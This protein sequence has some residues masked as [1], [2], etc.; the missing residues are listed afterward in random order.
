MSARRRQED[1]FSALE[2][3]IIVM[4]I[5]VLAAISV[6]NM[7]AASRSYKVTIAAEA[8]SQQLNRCRQEA[9]RKNQLV[10]IQ[11][12][13]HTTAIDLDDGGTDY[14]D[15]GTLVTVASDAT[16]TLV[17]PTNGIVTFTSRGEMPIGSN[18]N[19]TVS[20]GGRSRSVTIDP[21]GAVTIGAE[22]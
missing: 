16:I 13:A 7:V 4:V 12:T 5:L 1:G 6:P 20:Y 17:S 15:D 18:P 19:F 3:V 21:R 8:L 9:V 2:I 22:Q 10:P 14:T 11:V